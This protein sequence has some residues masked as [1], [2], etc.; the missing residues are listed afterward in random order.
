MLTILIYILQKVEIQ[1]GGKVESLGER[2][3]KQSIESNTNNH[4][5]FGGAN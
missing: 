5:Y 4:N 2:L 1:A 3:A